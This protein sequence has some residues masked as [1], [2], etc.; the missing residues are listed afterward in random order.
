MCGIYLYTVSVKPAA[1][2]RRTLEDTVGEDGFDGLQ[3]D[4]AREGQTGA[5]DAGLTRCMLFTERPANDWHHQYQAEKKWPEMYRKYIITFTKQGC[6]K[7][8][9]SNRKYTYNVK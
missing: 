8:I 4:R 7:L 6:I 9:K 2:T 5:G 1:M 3:T